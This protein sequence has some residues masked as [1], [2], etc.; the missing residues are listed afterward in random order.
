MTTET[1][2]VSPLLWR[3]PA[4]SDLYPGKRSADANR[5]AVGVSHR[6]IAHHSVEANFLCHSLVEAMWR[7]CPS[8]DPLAGDIASHAAF[9]AYFGTLPDPTADAHARV[10]KDAYATA[11][12]HANDLVEVCLRVATQRE[13]PVTDVLKHPPSL[14]AR[15][16]LLQSLALT[17]DPRRIA[18]HEWRNIGRALCSRLSENPTSDWPCGEITPRSWAFMR[19]RQGRHLGRPGVAPQQTWYVSKSPPSSSTPSFGDG[20]A[21]RPTRRQVLRR[22]NR[23]LRRFQYLDRED[24]AALKVRVRELHD[25]VTRGRGYRCAFIRRPSGK[26]RRLDVPDEDLASLQREF[27]QWISKSLRMPSE[28][29]GFVPKRSV[30][31]HARRHAGARAAA[32]VDIADFFGSVRPEQVRRGF[33][34]QN[35]AFKMQF[36]EI[37]QQLQNELVDTAFRWTEEGPPYLPQGAPSSPVLANIAARLLDSRVVMAA[38][39]AFGRGAYTYSRYADDLVLS[40]SYDIRDFGG[41]ARGILEDTIRS[42]HWHPSTTKSRTWC[43]G[44]FPLV[45]CGIVVPEAPLGALHLPRATMREV[46]SLLHRINTG[47]LTLAGRWDASR[48]E[49]RAGGLFGW[50]YAVS[51]E[52]GWLAF[53]SR[54]VRTLARELGC[55]EPFLNAFCAGWLDASTLKE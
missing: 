13:A 22:L 16:S 30:V 36:D 5:P 4:A 23:N 11:L 49:C 3:V 26:L 38:N 41:I 14:D 10:P 24:L 52:P 46:R 29:M 27:A 51:G 53:S 33:A 18:A 19:E 28:V 54:H 39:H 32:I 55:E 15:Y 48:P 6:R 12:A 37:G 8:D 47:D 17:P 34:S 21:K 44:D 40:T 45:L 7:E 50:I 35:A 20:Y 31:T 43:A 25:V 42:M 1:A 9:M 2:T